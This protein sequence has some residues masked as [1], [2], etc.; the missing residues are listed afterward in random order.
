MYASD[1]ALAG[2]ALSTRRDRNL[3]LPETGVSWLLASRE[4]QGGDRREPGKH[5]Y[6]QRQREAAQ[7]G[8]TDRLVVLILLPVHR[9]HLASFVQGLRCACACGADAHESRSRCPGSTVPGRARSESVDNSLL[10]GPERPGGS[11]LGATRSASS[12]VTV[13]WLRLRS[14]GNLAATRVRSAGR[15]RATR[16][17]FR[18]DRQRVLQRSRRGWATAQD[19]RR[20]IDRQVDAWKPNACSEQRARG[21]QHIGGIRTARER[22]AKQIGDA[23]A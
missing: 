6:G 20:P 22:R 23:F 11:S 8:R 19:D 2:F 21:E 13:C 14:A 3:G 12:R 17:R 10:E 9:R 15:I 4:G 1:Q 18:G 5:A 16:S 7:C